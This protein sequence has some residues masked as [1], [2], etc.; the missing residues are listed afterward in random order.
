M[1]LAEALRVT[2]LVARVLDDLK[3]PYLLGGSLASSLH[4]IPRS[5]EDADLVVELRPE[6]IRPLVAALSPEFYVD[7][8]RVAS[9]VRRRASFN[10]IYLATLIKVDLFVLKDDP[11]SRQEMERRQHLTLPGPEGWELPV[12]TAEDTVLQ[13]LAWF[14]LGGDVSERQW[15]DLLGVLKVKRGRLDQEYL[16]RWAA[17]LEVADLLARALEEAGGGRSA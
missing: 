15:D 9:A 6:H 14:R 4:G 13:K 5:T 3:V 12:A 10:I 16:A 7:E 8:E 11:L 2:L 17:E 1:E